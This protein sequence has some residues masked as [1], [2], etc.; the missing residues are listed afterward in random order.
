M[1]REAEK[2]PGIARDGGRSLGG[3][4]SAALVAGYPMMFSLMDMARL[5]T[6]SRAGPWRIAAE[7]SAAQRTVSEA[8]VNWPTP[9]CNTSCRAPVLVGRRI[10]LSA[11][12]HSSRREA[13]NVSPG[14]EVP[15][16]RRTQTVARSG[17]EPI[18]SHGKH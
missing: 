5:G 15:G 3:A 11:P 8:W 16:G 13:S 12:G 17:E 9:A 10:A 4:H 7:L 1:D 6:T 2:I 18:G 14:G